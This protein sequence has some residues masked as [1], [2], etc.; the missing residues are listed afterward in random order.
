[1]TNS[2]P[3]LAVQREALLDHD[4]DAAGLARWTRDLVVDATLTAG[5][6]AEV[7]LGTPPV[8]WSVHAGTA[9]RSVVLVD[10]DLDALSEASVDQLELRASHVWRDVTR[11]ALVFEP[12]PWI[13]AV[14]VT[15]EAAIDAAS[16][17]RIRHLVASRTLDAA[18]VVVADRR[19]RTVR[20]P[21]S[22]LSIESFLAALTGR[23][24][25]LAASHSAGEQ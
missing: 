15:D 18:C 1:M 20:S 3:D 19:A 7:Q 4:L 14:R 5:L 16:V 22:A 12:R 13:G 17:D 11:S 24:L 9:G 21:T 25:V 2:L 8:V 23:C 10:V 6:Q